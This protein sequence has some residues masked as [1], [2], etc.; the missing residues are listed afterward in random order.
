MIYNCQAVDADEDSGFVEFRR[1]SFGNFLTLNLGGVPVCGYVKI[2]KATTILSYI[3]FTIGTRT[4]DITI[5]FPNSRREST[6]AG[7]IPVTF[8]VGEEA[9]QKLKGFFFIAIQK[10]TFRFI[11]FFEHVVKI[12]DFGTNT[13]VFF[14]FLN[15]IANDNCI[16]N[17][18]GRKRTLWINFSEF[19][20]CFLFFL[21]RKFICLD[22]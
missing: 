17:N 9:S 22:A 11:H 16:I 5:I 8:L 12:V 2:A 4:N 14:Y 1:P 7:H 21:A 20:K 6:R 15:F 3:R 10:I 19:L 18:N 13:N